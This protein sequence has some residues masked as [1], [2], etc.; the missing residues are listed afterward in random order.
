MD[1]FMHDAEARGRRHRRRH[2]SSD[3]QHTQH[4]RRGEDDARPA[5]GPPRGRGPGRGRRG[6]RHRGDVRTAVLLLLAEEPM[7]GY[8]LMQTI[9]DRTN[10]SWAPSPGA[11]YPT[12]NQLEDEGLVTIAAEGGRKMVALT[13]AGRRHVDENREAWTNPFTAPTDGVNLRE[14]VHSL[15]E[16]SR[17][18]GR[19]GSAAQQTRAAEILAEARRALY[20]VLAEADS[21]ES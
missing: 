5:S 18:V 8:Q 12:I 3:E 16:A 15:A 9:S 17:Q 13:D 10:G 7:H 11:I 4:R 19:T 2:N 21:D 20:L 6:H 14:L 1:D